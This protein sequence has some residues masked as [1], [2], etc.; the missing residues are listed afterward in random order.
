[1]T[2]APDAPVRWWDPRTRSTRSQRQL[3]VAAVW[4]GSVIALACVPY[5]VNGLYARLLLVQVITYGLL[6][7]S[8]NLTLGI[9]GIFNF[10]HIALFGVGA[11]TS[12]ILVLRYEWDP[13]LTMPVAGVVSALASLIAFIPVIRLRGIYVAL[14][15]FIFSQL[16][17][18]LVLGQ[19]DITGGSSGLVGIPDLYVGSASLLADGRQGYVRLGSVLLVLVVSAALV[20]HRSTFG[21]SLLAIKDNE[22]LASSRGIPVFRLHLITFMIGSF[23]AGVT[24]SFYAFTNNVVSVDVL[25]FGYATLMLGMIFL[26]GSSSVVGPLLGAVVITVGS[27]Q[28][29]DHGPWRFIVVGIVILVVLRFFPRGLTG[30]LTS[31][32][33]RISSRRPVGRSEADSQVV[34]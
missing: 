14:A 29:R 18:Y 8:W 26:G 6:A 21:R 34:Q 12:A 3:T 5:I 7:V 23:M 25:S 10:A 11:Y 17:V 28:L 31:L 9:A 27:D 32:R 22:Q 24:G 19:R 2:P 30:G 13:W 15:T 4:I 1:M 20:L 33:E 16:C